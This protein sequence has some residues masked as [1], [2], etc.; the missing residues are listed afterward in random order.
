MEMLFRARWNV[1]QAAKHCSLSINKTKKLFKEYL[2]MKI[3]TQ[4]MSYGTGKGSGK[5]LEEQRAAIPPANPTQVNLLTDSLK[6]ELKDLINE[7][8][9][10]RLKHK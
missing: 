7:V 6:K 10:E 2:T 1:P 4:G 9:D 5:S 8:L 3:D